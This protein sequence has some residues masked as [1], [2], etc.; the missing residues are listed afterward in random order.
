MVAGT[1]EALVRRDRQ[2]QAGV[3]DRIRRRCLGAGAPRWQIVGQPDDP[4]QLSCI[5]VVLEY[6]SKSGSALR[7]RS[8]MPCQIAPLF[9]YRWLPP[10]G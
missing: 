8:I 7:H 9:R 2:V 3:A 5:E 1:P 4:I 10:A 6:Q